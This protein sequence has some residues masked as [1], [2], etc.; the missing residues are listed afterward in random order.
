MGCPLLLSERLHVGLHDSGEELPERDIAEI[1][2]SRPFGILGVS[3]DTA[4][5]M[6]KFC[7]KEGLTFKLLADTYTTVSTAYGSVMEYQGKKPS[8]E[9]HLH[10]RSQGKGRKGVSIREGTE[11]DEE[12]LAALW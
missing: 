10:N 3:V 9:K 11:A 1:T 4:E 6:Q 7:T 5:L 2:S 12:V 8:G